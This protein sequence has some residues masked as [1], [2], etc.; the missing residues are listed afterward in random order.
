M[1][2]EEAPPAYRKPARKK[3][4][5]KGDSDRSVEVLSYRHDEMRMNNPAVGMVHAGTDPDGDKTTW[6]Y[7]PHL[8]PVLNFHSAPRIGGLIDRVFAFAFGPYHLTAARVEG[9]SH[10]ALLVFSRSRNRT[11]GTAWHPRRA[12]ARIQINISLVA[13]EHLRVQI[14]I[15]NGQTG[16][17]SRPHGSTFICTSLWTCSVAMWW[18]GWWPIVSQ[19]YWPNS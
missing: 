7:D 11:L 15:S 3:M 9:T 5:A 4:A 8:D 18:A 2:V 12:D 16:S 13:V 10:V 17:K 14:G 1:Q 6:A 19:R